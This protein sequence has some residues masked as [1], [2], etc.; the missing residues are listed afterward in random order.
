M[1]P[2]TDKGFTI[3]FTGLSGAGKSTI[4]GFLVEKLKQRGLTRIEVLDGD[5]VRTN[6][7][8][9]LGFSREDRDINISRIGFVADLL[10]RNGVVVIVAAISPY[11]ETRDRVRRQIEKFV[12]VYVSA[13]L[14][15]LVERDVKGLYKR[16]LAGE[17]GNFTGVSDPYE[18]PLT[19][20]ITVET[21]KEAVEFSANKVLSTLE[22]MGLIPAGNGHLSKHEVEDV[23]TQIPIISRSQSK[24]NGHA[25]VPHGNL[26][27][28]VTPKPISPHGGN[29]VNRFLPDDERNDVLDRIEK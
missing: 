10:S 22:K 9:G 6:L 4:A 19:P 12:E 13:P 29:L 2:N 15:T 5:V 17:I 8:K 21:D 7:S 27:G 25:Q 28:E 14:K 20:E 11:R 1:T 23:V 24:G 18:P 26:L 3:W 16:A